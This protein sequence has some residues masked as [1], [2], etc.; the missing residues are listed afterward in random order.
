MAEKPITLILGET[1]EQIT[2]DSSISREDLYGRQK[3]SVEKD[4]TTLEK[5][6]V[7]P[8]GELF[9]PK[10][11][12]SE[13]IDSEGSIAEKPNQCDENGNILATN[14]TSFKE[15]RPVTAAA[16]HEL[17]AFK[18][19]SVMPAKTSLPPGLYRTQFCYR[20]SV[21]LHDAF[22]VVRED[23]AFLLTGELRTVPAAGREETY[24][25]FDDGSSDEEIEDEDE[26]GFDSL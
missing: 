13:A 10:A 22:L 24:E 20:D 17:A 15:A 16:W 23:T 7:T 2:L 12:K 8:W 26:I 14:I 1:P 4:G 9:P 6:V 3:G 25:F 5:V 19:E 21:T 11:L 18:T